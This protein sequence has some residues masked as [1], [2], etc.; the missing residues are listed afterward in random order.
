VSDS[1]RMAREVFL[2]SSETDRSGG[3]RE[4]RTAILTAVVVALS[5]LLGWM[6]GRAGWNMAVNQGEK[7]GPESREKAQPA[8]QMPQQPVPSPP[9]DEEL[10]KV[11][12]QNHAATT[13]PNAPA[14]A[15]ASSGPKSKTA[16][17]QPDGALVMYERG[18]KVYRAA[19]TS[20]AASQ[21]GKSADSSS[22]EAPEITPSPAGSTLNKKSIPVKDGYVTFRLVPQ[23]PE[24]ARRQRI[25]GPVVLSVL[26]GTDGSVQQVKL[27]TGDAR[28]APAAADAVR[29]WR[30]KPHSSHG[31]PADFETRITVNFSLP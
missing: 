10:P 7:Q 8:T 9:P 29:Q 16:S 5:L 27:V 22:A 19:P 18:R 11:V 1:E 20:H 24:E 28:L 14:S 15:S 31:K 2:A 30:F 25:Q 3:P 21:S 6:V 26:V 13:G 17:V 23:Y 4:Y 12:D